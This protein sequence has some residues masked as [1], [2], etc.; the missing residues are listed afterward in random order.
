MNPATPVFRAGQTSTGLPR[1]CIR[2]VSFSGKPRKPTTGF[3]GP[4]GHG[5][6][7]WIWSHRRTEQT[8][9]TFRDRLVVCNT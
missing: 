2:H 4:E 9:Y 7:I 1:L 6:K 8:I 5:E 3:V